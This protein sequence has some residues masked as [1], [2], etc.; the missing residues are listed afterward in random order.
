MFTKQQHKAVAET[1]VIHSHFERPDSRAQELLEEVVESLC[2][3]FRKDNPNFD[4]G[5]FWKACFHGPKS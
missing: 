4:S 3:M 2:A 5:K 1:L